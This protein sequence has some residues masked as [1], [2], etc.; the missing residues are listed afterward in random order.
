MLSAGLRYSDAEDVL[1]SVPGASDS[2]YRGF[3]R[4]VVEEVYGL[5]RSRQEVSQTEKLL[6]EDLLFQEIGIYPKNIRHFAEF[7][8]AQG[9][10]LKQKVGEV[11][12]SQNVGSRK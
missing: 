5:N 9:N 7:F 1:L 10:G 11:E 2:K 6:L 12:E 4:F 8:V 3:V